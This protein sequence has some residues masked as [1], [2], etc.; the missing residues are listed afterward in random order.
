MAFDYEKRDYVPTGEPCCCAETADGAN[1]FLK[2]IRQGAMLPADAETAAA[3]GVQFSELEVDQSDKWA[4]PKVAA[5]A[6]K[7]AEG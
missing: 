2:A 7:K 4:K 1:E 5:R 6:A 3:A